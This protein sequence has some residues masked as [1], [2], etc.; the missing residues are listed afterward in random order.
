[1]NIYFPPLV[2]DVSHIQ[3]IK[4]LSQTPFLVIR[5]SEMSCLFSTT[6]SAL[7]EPEI[8]LLAQATLTGLQ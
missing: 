2:C 1:M 5:F 3:P 8:V 6:L 4:A 7:S